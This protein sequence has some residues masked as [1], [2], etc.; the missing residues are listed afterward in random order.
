MKKVKITTISIF[1]MAW[2]LYAAEYHVSP[3]G[4][5]SNNGSKSKPF[6]TISAAVAIAL[7]GDTVT[8]HE[9]VYRERVNPPRGG[10]SEDMRIV[11]QAAPGEK[12]VIKG[13]EVIKTWKKVQDGMWKV[14]LSNQI[15]GYYNPYKDTI[16]GEWYNTPADGFNRHTGAVYLNGHWLPEAP[17]KAGLRSPDSLFN[18]AWL[19]T[20]GYE[21]KRVSASDMLSSQGI[22]EATSKEEG[23][24]IGSISDGDWATY[25]I[26]FGKSSE[27]IEFRIA[28][29]NHGG[30][31]E[32]RFDSP[33]G[34]V[35]ATCAVPPKLDGL[36]WRTIQAPIDP[37]SGIKKVCLVFKELPKN[38]EDKSYWFAE[39]DN[40]NTTIWARFGNFDPNKE[41]VEINVRQSVFYP[42]QP[43]RNYITVRGFTM[44][45][46][47]TPWSGAMSDQIGL[48]GTH[49][50]KG[51]VIENNVI[52]YSM[53]SGIT[54]GCFEIED[55]PPATA[56]GY[57]D[58]IRVAFQKGWSKE[59]IG[60]HIVRNNHISFCEKN[61]I[62]GSLGG[63][64]STIEGN[65]I[66]DIGMN[67]WIAG[68]D[69]AGLKLLASNDVLIRNNHF[70]RCGGYGALWLDWMAQGTRVTGN[71][72]HDNLRD[73]FVEVNHGPFLVDNNV[74]LSKFSLWES[75]EGG[76][77]VHNLI[78]G[79]IRLRS[80]ERFTP[81]F[82]P[83]TI[84]D[85]KLSNFT[86]GDERYYNNLF[87]GY[88]GLSIYST[89]DLH[90]QAAGN[91]FLAGSKPSIFDREVLIDEGFNP[92]VELEEKQDGW[93][94]AMSVDPSWTTNQKRTVVCT[95]ILGR[96]IVPDQAY[97]NPD[98]SPIRFDTDYFG[99]KRN[100]N[101]PAPGPIEIKNDDKI[102]VKVWPRN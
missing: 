19:Q 62:H 48:I 83:H 59:N 30:I 16:G 9:G 74:L 65:T 2:S 24:Y 29:R 12:V 46:A 95:D 97:E 55:M 94:L 36:L 56:T 43:G 84:G 96:A 60:S 61:G 45:H 10:T 51:W 93:W 38:D 35:M 32:I 31:I 98:G 34:K 70:Y 15:F 13:S 25:D 64:F 18:V 88:Q 91:V 101:T 87:I 73:I 63:I 52:S 27:H 7:A 21:T 42:D 66:S 26:D 81:Y 37:T 4:N 90:I 8:V 71:L 86:H 76:A 47:A 49:W 58:Y 53:N 5:D 44:C 41:M 92:Q 79:D 20:T 99:E 69:V 11:Y 14:I 17:V 102:S 82:K 68:P 100:K 57:V 3:D 89:K 54:L 72:F 22:L 50:S 77:Y 78:A 23:A 75:S 85:M 67:Q 1:L 33:Q 6:K 28:S 39:V 40:K 80:E